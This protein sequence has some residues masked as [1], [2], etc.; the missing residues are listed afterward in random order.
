MSLT[1]VGSIVSPVG[2]EL[3]GSIVQLPSEVPATAYLKT[4]SVE[5]SLT[6]QSDVPS[7][8]MSMGL[9]LPLLRLKLLAAVWLPESRL[10]APVYLNTL[11][12]VA[13]TIQTSLP[14]VAMPSGFPF[15]AIEPALHEPSRLPLMS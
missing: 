3:A 1:F 6:T 11:S 12:L 4:L 13:S 9:A 14:L 10:A 8:T 15:V 7:V 2:L 5:E